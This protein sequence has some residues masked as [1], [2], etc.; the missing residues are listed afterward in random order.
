MNNYKRNK[1]YQK[2]MY[3]LNNKILKNLKQMHLE[4]LNQTLM[5]LRKHKKNDL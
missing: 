3:P 4:L 5:I 1:N 2:I